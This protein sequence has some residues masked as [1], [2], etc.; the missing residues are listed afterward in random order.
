MTENEQVASVGSLD[1][2]LTSRFMPTLSIAGIVV[3]V[4][5]TEPEWMIFSF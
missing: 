5:G 3:A 4:A 1:Y 2:D